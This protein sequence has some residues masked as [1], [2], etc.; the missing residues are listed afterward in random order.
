MG[1]G[2]GGKVWGE[3]EGG[4]VEYGSHRT[5]NKMGIPTHNHKRVWG[6]GNKET[7]R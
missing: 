1:G 7:D 4:V 6:G 3:E 5:E 2:G